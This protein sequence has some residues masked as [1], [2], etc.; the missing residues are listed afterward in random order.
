ML[1]EPVAAARHS[2]RCSRCRCS[3]P[4]AAGCKFGTGID[5]GGL[6]ADVNRPGSDASG[7]WDGATALDGNFTRRYFRHV[8][9]Y[10]GANNG[11]II[12]EPATTAQ[13]LACA[14]IIRC[15]PGRIK[16]Q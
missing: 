5:I 1:A 12:Q 15:R 10:N 11:V 2:R 8:T 16:R 3:P 13:E 4:R 9:A 14:V 6:G 7:D